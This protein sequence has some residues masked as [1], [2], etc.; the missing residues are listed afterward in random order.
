VRIQ[1]DD[2]GPGIPEARR[3]LVFDRFARAGNTTSG[4]VGL[5]LAIVRRHVA[6]HGGSVGVEDRPGGGA[7][8]VITL[9]LA[10]P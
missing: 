8:F 5:G 2:R 10:R 7:R 9:P 1:V 4:G 6:A 3:A